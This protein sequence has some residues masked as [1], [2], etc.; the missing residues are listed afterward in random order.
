MWGEIPAR[1]QIYMRYGTFIIIQGVSDIVN[2][3]AVIFLSIGNYFNV[4]SSLP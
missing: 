1:I 4:D 3:F 2:N